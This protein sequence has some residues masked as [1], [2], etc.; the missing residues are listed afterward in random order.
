MTTLKLPQNRLRIAFFGTPDIARVMLEQ[1]L[2]ADED[3]VVLVVSQPDRPKGRGKKLVPTPVKAL[4]ESRG[5][6]VTQPKK[7]RD[8]VLTQQLRDLEVQLAVVV[9]YGRIL[10]T[11]LFEAPTFDTW[12]VH[13]SLLPRHR[14]A[15]PIQHA[16]LCGDAQTGVT[17]MMLSEAMDEGH[18]L[19]KKTRPLDGTET[20]G[21]LTEDLGPIGGALL[22][23]GL[24]RA[25]SE[26]LTVTPQDEDEVT[27]ASLIDKKAG[28]LDFNEPAD[29]L[30]RRIRAYQPWPTCFVPTAAGPLKILQARVVASDDEQ[31]PGTVLSTKP[32]LL[33]RCATGALAIDRVQPPGKKPMP[34]AA[35]LN[36]AGRQIQIGKALSDC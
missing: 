15:S 9:A 35:F 8:G 12:N 17:L 10:P 32:D 36:G 20:G 21:S 25:K 19:L 5:V 22:V 2:D 7:L 31:A 29:V 28:A 6:P 27:Y 26:G 34:T 33:V 16:I 23:E 18:M 3:D 30:E 1:L 24:R 11:D 13:A 14:G 4:A